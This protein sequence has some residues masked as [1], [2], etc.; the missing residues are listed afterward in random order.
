MNLY[1][2]YREQCNFNTTENGALGYETTRSELLDFQYKV[3]SYRNTS[4][5]V[6]VEDF[7]KVINEDI[8]YALKLL[9]YIRDVREGLGERRLF[10]I[11]LPVLV[12]E[13]SRIRELNQKLFDWVVEYGRYDDLFCLLNTQLKRDVLDYIDIQLAE[14]IDNAADGKPISLLAKWLPSENA[15]SEQTKKYAR[16]IR[17]FLCLSSRQYRQML[18]FL[19]KHLDVLEVK[20]SAKRWNEIDYSKVPSCAN[21]K[22]EQAFLRNDEDRRLQYLNDVKNG[23]KKINTSVLYPHDIVR[24]YSLGAENTSLE[25]MWSNL[26][27][28]FNTDKNILVVRDGSGSMNCSCI[29]NTNVTPLTVATALAIYCSERLGG[30]FKN[31]FI[32]FSSRPKFIDL[33][34]CNTLLEKLLRTYRQDDCSNTN[35]ELTMKLI[36]D[37]AV[38]NNLKQED[39]PTI[40]ILSDMEFDCAVD[41]TNDRLF[42]KIKA[43]FAEKGYELPKIIF[44]NLASRTGTIP[45]ISNENGVTLMSGFSTNALKMALDEEVDPLKMLMNILNSDRYKDIQV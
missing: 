16:Q 19:R 5:E 37:T 29:G 33:S 26:K 20:T 45:M 35:I 7:K 23:V 31:K 36:L 1:E 6:I 24:K 13:D 38:K 39:I 27:D 10:R 22:Y 9:F 40:M 11:C 41:N 30:D 3:S 8:N 43:Q 12:N 15:S 28:T 42:D 25:L 21:V 14:D 18:T 32:T 17:E 2:L 44:W 34:N 4:E